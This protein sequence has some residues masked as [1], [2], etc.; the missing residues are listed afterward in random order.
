MGGVI[1]T[2]FSRFMS[3]LTKKAAMAGRL[4]EKSPAY[5]SRLGFQ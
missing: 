3:S 4:R 1:A 2:R 5:L